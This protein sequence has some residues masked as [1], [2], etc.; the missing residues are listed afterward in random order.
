[1]LNLNFD[2]TA[3]QTG[4][5]SR[6]ITPMNLPCPLQSRVHVYLSRTSA[7]LSQRPKATGVISYK[8]MQQNQIFIKQTLRCYRQYYKD[9]PFEF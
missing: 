1:M 5:E 4:N 2:A 3:F 6:D 7:P 9:A 8:I